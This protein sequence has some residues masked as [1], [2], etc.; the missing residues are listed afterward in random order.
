MDFCLLNHLTNL[1]LLIEKLRPLVSKVVTER[2]ILIAILLAIFFSIFTFSPI[3]HFCSYSFICFLFKVSLCF[4]S[5]SSIDSSIL[6]RAGLVD[7]NSFHLFIS[8]KVFLLLSTVLYSFAGYSNLGWHLWFFRTWNAL[9]PGFSSFNW[10]TGGYF[11][12]LLLLLFWRVN[13]LLFLPVFV[14]YIEC[15]AKIFWGS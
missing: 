8:W 7:T 9:V 1:Y 11:D 4:S 15:L 10:E 12:V 14:L 6:C 5:F 2:C 3:L 13:F